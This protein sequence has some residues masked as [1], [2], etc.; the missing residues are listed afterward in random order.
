MLGAVVEEKETRIAEILFSSVRP[1]TLMIGKLIGVSLMAMT[2]LSIWGLAFGGLAAFLV[3]ALI[4][5][6]MDVHLPELPKGFFLFFVLFFILGYF[7]YATLYLLVGS[8]VTT[9]QEGGQL[10]AN[11]FPVGGRA[12]YG[13]RG[14]PQSQL[15]SFF[16]DIADAFLLTDHYDG[17]YCFFDTAALANRALARHR[18]RHRGVVAL[19]GGSRISRRHADVRQEGHNSGSLALA[20]SVVNRSSRV[21]GV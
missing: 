10:H 18:L 1:F 8:M 7:L 11:Y 14:D 15:T 6:G 3:P 19:G 5:Q 4:A 17:A 9:A 20:A 2:Q 13:V 16:L 12:L 21:T